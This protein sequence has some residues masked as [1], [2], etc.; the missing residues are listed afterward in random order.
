MMKPKITTRMKKWE[1]CK[2]K[3]SIMLLV[4]YHRTCTYDR[5]KL[6]QF[7]QSQMVHQHRVVDKELYKE[8]YICIVVVL[9]YSD[10]RIAKGGKNES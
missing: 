7:M 2:M 10:Y 8:L 6:R 5:S 1:L 4:Y 9:G 3:E